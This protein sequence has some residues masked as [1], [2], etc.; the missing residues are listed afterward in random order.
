M[1]ANLRMRVSMR[2]KFKH[3]IGINFSLRQLRECHLAP[4]ETV[5]LEQIIIIFS[6]RD[7]GVEVQTILNHYP[8]KGAI[9]NFVQNKGETQLESETNAPRS[10]G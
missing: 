9:F 7:R 4:S 2:T 8:K 10:G 3:E 1:S 5:I 6:N